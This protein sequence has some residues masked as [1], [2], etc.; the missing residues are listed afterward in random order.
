MRWKTKSVFG[1]ANT[2]GRLMAPVY[3]R[4]THAAR[5]YRPPQAHAGVCA[6]CWPCLDGRRATES[7]SAQILGLGARPTSGDEPRARCR[8]ERGFVLVGCIVLLGGL[9]RTERP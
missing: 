5:G 6:R 2:G 4:S 9:W 3:T 1:S 8:A 7:V